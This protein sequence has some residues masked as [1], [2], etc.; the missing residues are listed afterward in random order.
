[1]GVKVVPPFVVLKTP[2]EAT[3]TYQVARS[4]GC[5]AMSAIRPEVTAGPIPRSSRPEKVSALSLVSDS[6]FES[7][8]AAPRRE[9]VAVTAGRHTV[10][11]RT[12]ASHE[13]L[14]IAWSPDRRKKSEH[15]HF[16]GL[17]IL[18]D[19]PPFPNGCQTPRARD[20]RG[21]LDTAET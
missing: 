20:G 16:S 8:L 14:R 15:G 13:D 21:V 6:F 1:M 4:V 17:R 9:L 19:S 11:S 5:T 3:A 10:S 2:P 12:R 18:S 7:F